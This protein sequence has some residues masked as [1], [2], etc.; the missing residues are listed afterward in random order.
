MT[1]FAG[2]WRLLKSDGDMDIGE[3]VTMTFTADGKLVYVVHQKGSDQIMSLTFRINGES[4]CN[5][6]GLSA[7]GRR[8]SV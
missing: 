8:D 1:Q 4:T 5:Q 6:S 2:A 7:T 3:G